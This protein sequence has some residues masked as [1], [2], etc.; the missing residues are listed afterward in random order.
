MNQLLLLI[1]QWTSNDEKHFFFFL[2]ILLV[3]VNRSSDETS[4][5]SSTVHQHP[6]RVPIPKVIELPGSAPLPLKLLLQKYDECR[7]TTV[8]HLVTLSHQ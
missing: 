5:G 1:P 7:L 2:D 8:S 6:I 4:T 3:Q